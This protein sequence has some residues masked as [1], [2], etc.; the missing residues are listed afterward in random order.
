MEVPIW[1]RGTVMATA[2]T[3]I[4]EAGRILIPARLR[5]QLGIAPCDAVV[6]KT[7]GR[8]LHLRSYKKAIEEAQVIIGKYIP[9]RERSLVDELIEQRR[10]EAERE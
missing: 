7:Q 10:R 5:R 1:C 4:D 9:D 2:R 3:K 8:E 6:L